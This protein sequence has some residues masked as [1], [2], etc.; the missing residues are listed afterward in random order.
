MAMEVEVV[1]ITEAARIYSQSEI[2][3]RR[4]IKAGKLNAKQ[5]GKWGKYLIPITELRNAFVAK[6]TQEKKR[7][8]CPN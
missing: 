1:S 8:E 3:I 7:E 6:T 2:T 5:M 4:M